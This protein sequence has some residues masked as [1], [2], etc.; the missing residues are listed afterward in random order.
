MGK[1]NLEGTRR[2]TVGK[3]TDNYL[4]LQECHETHGDGNRVDVRG[5]PQLY[6]PLYIPYLLFIF[7]LHF[8]LLT[9]L[10][11]TVWLPP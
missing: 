9:Y 2:R 11:V 6:V 10:F 7:H 5:H 3:V 8:A 1:Q 4:H